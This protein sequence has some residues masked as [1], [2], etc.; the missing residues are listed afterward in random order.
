[1]AFKINIV[2]DKI[3]CETPIANGR[4]AQTR[5]FIC[6]CEARDGVERPVLDP[7]VASAVIRGLSALRERFAIDNLAL[8]LGRRWKRH[9]SNFVVASATPRDFA[10]DVSQVLRETCLALINNPKLQNFI[11]QMALELLTNFLASAFTATVCNDH[12]VH[13][14]ALLQHPSNRRLEI[15]VN[16]PMEQSERVW[17]MVANVRKK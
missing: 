6:R 14:I 8:A 12:N 9:E 17:R 11:L 13:L 2:L 5:C 16:T 1:M 10:F 4:L 7:C 15:L 3:S